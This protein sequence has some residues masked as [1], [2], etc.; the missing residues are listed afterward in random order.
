MRDFE[1]DNVNDSFCFRL[2][3]FTLRLAWR[4]KKCVQRIMF[5]DI[6][7]ARLELKGVLIYAEPDWSSKDYI[8]SWIKFGSQLSLHTYEGIYKHANGVIL[9]EVVPLMECIYLVVF[10]RMLG[11]SYRRRFGA[12]L[13]CP[14]LQWSN[15]NIRLTSVECAFRFRLI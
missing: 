6:R 15:T 14:M 8:Q 11:D 10:T 5:A 4:P 12:L 2:Q 9:F 1:L 3:P 7:W 13:L